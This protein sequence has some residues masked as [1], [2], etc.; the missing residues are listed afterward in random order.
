MVL[1]F[2]MASSMVYELIEWV[3]AIG[4]SPDAAEKYNGQQGDLWDAHKDMLMA[5]IGTLMFGLL[6]LLGNKKHS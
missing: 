2:V 3:I 6:Q 4:M 5:T 1:Q